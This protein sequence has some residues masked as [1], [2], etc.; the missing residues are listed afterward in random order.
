[1]K[2]LA[3]L[4]GALVG[5]LILS[6]LLLSVSAV[7]LV[8]GERRVF[9][10]QRRVGKGGK[11]FDLLKF[12]TMYD[13]V[14]ARP[15]GG[16]AVDTD[17]EVFPF[18]R[19]LRRTKINELPQ[20]FNVIR[21]DMGLVG[22]RPLTWRTLNKYDPELLE[23]I[24]QRRPGLTGAA[25]LVFRDEE[26]ILARAGSNRAEVFNTQIIPRKQRIEAEYAANASLMLDVKIV[27]ATAFSVLLPSSDVP[28]KLLPDLYEAK[29]GL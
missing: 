23:T 10:R 27:L 6:P 25:S 13:S 3:D 26:E 7:L 12:T 8:V 22:P 5:T 18:G 9:Y 16:M 14:A 24:L 2:R 17:P 21:G 11:E 20:L 28:R 29:E 15:D 1:M 19:F 4:F